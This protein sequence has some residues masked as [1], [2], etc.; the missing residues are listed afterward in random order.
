[1]ENT[2]NTIITIT[3]QESTISLFLFIAIHYDLT[4]EQARK[5]G[6][7]RAFTSSRKFQKHI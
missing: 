5:Q 3:F 2:L 1:M 7:S 6:T 4:P